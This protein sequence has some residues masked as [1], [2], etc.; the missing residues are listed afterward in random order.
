MR[1]G[2]SQY[3]LDGYETPAPPESMAEAPTKVGHKAPDQPKKN[4]QTASDPEIQGTWKAISVIEGGQERR[5]PSGL[6]FTFR[7]DQM[8][9]NTAEGTLKGRH[10][11]D[12]DQTSKH[13]DQTHKSKGTLENIY[14]IEGNTLRISTFGSSRPRPVDFNDRKEEQTVIV[15]ERRFPRGEL[16]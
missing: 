15:L 13:L 1:I 9:I 10:R 2:P 8:V 11:V 12:L 3:L 4:R 7:G 6:R 16:R 14:A 5:A